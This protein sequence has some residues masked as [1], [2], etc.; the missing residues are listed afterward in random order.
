MDT[1]TSVQLSSVEDPMDSLTASVRQIHK[2]SSPFD[3]S[4]LKLD[5]E[6]KHTIVIELPAV[7]ESD[8]LRQAYAHSGKE[9][10]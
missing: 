3:F 6:Q 5:T 1:Q 2:L 9:L 8:T 7:G 10:C 4:T